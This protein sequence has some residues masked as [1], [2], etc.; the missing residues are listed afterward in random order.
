MIS[1]E[2]R[3]RIQMLRQAGH[4][5]RWIARHLEIS[6]NTVREI[7]EPE[8]A[9]RRRTKLEKERPP[10]KGSLLDPF[11]ARIDKLLEEDEQLAEK[12]RSHKRLTTTHILKD[13]RRLG[14]RGSRTILDDYLRERRGRRRRG[15]KV[16]RRFE[17]APAEEAQQDWSPYVVEIGGKSVRV[18]VFSLVLCW[19]R[20]QFLR[21][22]LDQKRPSLLWGHAAAFR[23]FEGVPWRIVYDRQR[24]IVA[25]VID[26][27]PIL[28]D[29]FRSFSDHYGF[30]AKICKPRDAPRKGRVER[31]FELFETSFLP[32][33]TFRSLEDLNRQIGDWLDG[34][35][36]P[37]EGNRRR[38]GTTAEVP[39]ERWQE[40]KRYLLELPETDL[41]P[42]RIEERLV[43]K[44]A[45]ISVEGTLYTVP[46]RLVEEGLRK[47]WVSIAEEDFAVHDSNGEVIARHRIQRD[48]KLVIDEEHYKE[49]GRSGRAARRERQSALEREL[50]E[51]FTSGAE[52]LAAMKSALR[53]ITPIHLREISA[54]RG[55]YRREEVEA[56]LRRALDDGTPT[57]GY[58]R[59]LLE[60]RHPTG[61][62]GQIEL[63]KPK[64]LA[65]G[66]VDP[67]C[68][69]GY[70]AIFDAGNDTGNNDSNGDSKEVGR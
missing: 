7:L 69:D 12:K 21:A 57:A 6:R 62:L 39:H 42:R 43:A 11:R 19:S 47:V 8:R 54:L 4:G 61:R 5:I 53:S 16:Y 33:R 22:Y 45:T 64:G 29:E 34:V 40:E 38:H 70:G 20:Q 32:R 56:A 55:R 67:G 25:A 23:Y 2:E 15:R 35:E 52:F 66:Q 36:F 26:G 65:L 63:E 27:E 14:Y 9:E 24:T 49:L 59:Q 3:K 10:K 41:V 46:A 30:K 31:A 37:E 68:A 18:E 60:R 51:G 44:D 48:K 1:D 13:L 58:V 17:T 50:V 28:Q